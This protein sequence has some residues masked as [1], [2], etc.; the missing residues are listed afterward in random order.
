MLRLGRHDALI[1]EA[2]ETI[3]DHPRDQD[4]VRRLMAA[5]AAAGR[6]SDAK[7]AYEELE[8]RLAGPPAPELR[9][10]LHRI[11][12]GTPAHPEPGPR[13]P[14]P[15]QLHDPVPDFTGRTAALRR[16]D[17]SRV[18]RASA[19]VVS[20]P[21]GIGKT[22][23][24]LAWAH[25]KREDFPDGQLFAD[26]RG[27]ARPAAPLDVLHGFMRDLGFPAAAIPADPDQ[28]AADFRAYAAGR[29]LLLFLDDA[30]DADQVLPLLP[31]TGGTFTIVTARDPMD[32]LAARSDIDTLALDG[33]D[34]AEAEA[35]LLR[36]TGT[37]P[38]PA[39][40][41]SLAP[42]VARCGG[43]PL[44]LSIAAD[45]LADPAPTG[46]HRAARPGR[47]DLQAV[48]DESFQRLGE[49]Q[50]RLYLALAPLP[51]PGVPADL[52]LALARRSGDDPQR[53]L[54]DL[55]D[56]RWLLHGDGRYTS[57]ALVADYAAAR[58]ARELTAAERDLVR[59]RV[60]A[61][62][63]RRGADV[64]AD[65]YDFLTA[66]YEA[67]WDHPNASRLASVLCAYAQRGHRPAEL[68]R[69]GE[70]AAAAAA[71]LGP[72][73]R[74]R[75]CNLVVVAAYADGDPATAVDYGRRTLALLE[76]TPNADR[77]GTARAN[78]G[79]ALA[80]LG[81]HREALPVLEA[82][83]AAARAGGA[84][85]GV[86]TASLSLANAHK[87]LGDTAAAEAV[88]LAA[89]DVDRDRS[90][91]LRATLITTHLD[92]LRPRTAREE[93]AP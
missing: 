72:V 44:A 76:R 80:R 12:S 60:I 35:L 67:W 75:H 61:H 49:P 26:L 5:L 64:P 85:D 56:S 88:L 22:A 57:H 71:D 47:T 63:H 31:G 13:T 92:D 9:D 2:R 81:R 32:P 93:A 19:V 78:L 40:T 84:W 77:I 42:L 50:R 34:D 20:G 82:A 28:V 41:A 39:A 59:D 45:L 14:G 17:R 23:L 4:A 3:R 87:G 91:G 36:R 46:R 70:R 90:R 73:E 10:L 7:Q 15:H 24:G 33:M 1:G 65:D 53:L 27:T 48:L 62:Y 68:A 29:R 18:R 54:D 79:G 37:A 30:R 11:E 51:G 83:V 21:A 8:A 66:A 25:R 6:D 74:A 89:R 55:V 43:L 69:L 52:A 16:L 86:V 38:S 58:A